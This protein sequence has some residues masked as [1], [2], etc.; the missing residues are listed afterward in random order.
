MLLMVSN[1]DH[2]TGLAG[3]T[4][5]LTASK[6]G[7]A[8][9]SITPTVTDRGSGWYG[10]MLTSAMTDT[11]GDLCL[12]ATATGADPADRRFEVETYVE[13]GVA[14]KTAMRRV[15]SSVAGKLSGAPAGPIFI[16]N[17]GD[18]K[19][20]ITATVDSSGNRTAISYDDS[21]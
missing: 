2:V 16:R 13:T 20:R 18:T 12:H 5:A 15:L 14:M 9:A 4:L 8:F 1:G 17:A 11:P 19:T 10:V 3:L 7:A 6:D 21:D